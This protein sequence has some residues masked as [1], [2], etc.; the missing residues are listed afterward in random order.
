MHFSLQ[1]QEK[2]GLITDARLPVNQTRINPSLMVD[3][4]PWLSINIAGAHLYGRSNF[5]EVEDSRLWFGINSDN[6]RYSEPTKN[7]K[8]YL[9]AE[10]MGPSATINIR[11]HA[12]GFHTA[13]RLY[14]N[15][16]KIPSVLG[17]IVGDGSVENIQDGVYT[18]N[19]ARAKEMSWVEFGLS[20]G[21]I[22]YQLNNQMVNVGATVNRIFGYQQANFIINDAQ[23]DV[24]DGDGTLRNLDGK[25]SYVDPSWASG[26]G[27][28]MDLG[29]NYRRSQVK[30]VL[31]EYYPHA[32]KSSCKRP[33]YLYSFGVSLLDLGYS[34]FTESA[35][36]SILPDT[37]T[38]DDLESGT[39]E[40]LGTEKSKFTAFLPTALAMQANYRYN[41]YIYVS[42]NLVQK[43]S[44]PNTF[45]VERA[46]VLG[47]TPRFES[48]WLSV[49]L[50][51]SLANYTTPQLGL[52]CRIGPLAVGTDH[53]S[54]FILKR[55]IRAADIYVYLNLPLSKSPECRNKEARSYNKW[56]C[57]V[58]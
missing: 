57:P 37:S 38:V 27:W 42:A 39:E 12:F 11:R 50:P 7:G 40:V 51:L 44:F 55:D 43:I 49:G 14:G 33:T 16:N 6:Y 53:L 35:R 52:Y 46:N 8:A 17:Q 4:K 19:N 29:I 36:T 26:K 58:W 20:Y 32:R 15:V 5:F 18:A 25:Y 41:D 13:A 34:R 54:P 28:S 10:V 30:D 47:L 21:T 2:L 1:A 31:N 22:V 56:V 24:V 9:H 23:V 3:Q 48:S 45:G